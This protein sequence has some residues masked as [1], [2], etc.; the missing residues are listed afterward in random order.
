MYLAHVYV[1][2]SLVLSPHREGNEVRT[3]EKCS[4]KFVIKLFYVVFSNVV[5]V[6]FCEK[7]ALVNTEQTNTSDKLRTAKNNLEKGPY[8]LQ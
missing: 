7:I 4:E 3:L 5:F 8:T 1:H 6:S 2:S